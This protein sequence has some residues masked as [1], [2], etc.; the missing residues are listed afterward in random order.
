MAALEAAYAYRAAR[1]FCSAWDLS[2]W[3]RRRKILFTE[4]AS[5]RTCAS[6][7]R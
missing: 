1:T 4:P 6:F 5:K 2:I 3:A 7:S